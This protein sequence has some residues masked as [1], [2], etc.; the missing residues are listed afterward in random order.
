MAERT[1]F[2]PARLL[3]QHDF[4]SCALS[5][6]RPSLQSFATL[7][8]ILEN[9]RKSKPF[10]KDFQNIFHSVISQQ[11]VFSLL[12][13]Y[14]TV[15]SS[16]DRRQRKAQSRQQ[17]KEQTRAPAETSFVSVPEDALK[18][19]QKTGF[20]FPGFIS[21]SVRIRTGDIRR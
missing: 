20:L 15:S 21:G 9:P 11:I 1:G 18:S 4:Q 14:F 6:T 17:T 12:R 3:H 2:E 7:I 13:F 19:R 5:Q 8:I 16:D 10:L